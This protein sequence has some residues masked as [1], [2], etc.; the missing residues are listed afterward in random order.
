VK[1]AIEKQEMV[2]RIKRGF[3]FGCSRGRWAEGV[4]RSQKGSGGNQEEIR[5]KSGGNQGES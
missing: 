4:R 3:S 5:R 2:K 1:T